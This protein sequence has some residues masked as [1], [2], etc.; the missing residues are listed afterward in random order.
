MV[1]LGGLYIWSRVRS[2]MM[3]AE[4]ENPPV[5]PLFIVLVTYGGWLMILL[6]ALVVVLVGNGFSRL[7]L[8]GLH[9]TGNHGHPGCCPLSA[10]SVVPVP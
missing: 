3:E 8:F 9:C 4:V 7:D 5:V 6:T 2:N 1:P 10:T